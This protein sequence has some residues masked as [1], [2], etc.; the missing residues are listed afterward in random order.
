[1]VPRVFEKVFKK[2]L[3]ELHLLFIGVLAGR[4]GMDYSLNFFGS[5]TKVSNVRFSLGEKYYL[6]D[7]IKEYFAEGHCDAFDDSI[8]DMLSSLTTQYESYKEKT[9][10]GELSKTPQYWLTYLDLRISTN[11]GS[12]CRIRK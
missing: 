4:Q 1:M 8:V 9:R 11:N 5:T 7:E 2:K 12:L 10:S 6:L 3:L